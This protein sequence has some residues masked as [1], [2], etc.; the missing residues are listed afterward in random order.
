[1][2][3][4]VAASSGITPLQPP[5]DEPPSVDPQANANDTDA[6]DAVTTEAGFADVY[7]AQKT[8]ITVINELRSAVGL[9]E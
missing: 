7:D 3:D 9:L 2:P 8:V 5:P 6:A 4:D 1:M